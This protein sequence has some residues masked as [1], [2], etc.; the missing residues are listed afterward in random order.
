METRQSPSCGQPRLVEPT[1]SA[2][3]ACQHV[4]VLLLRVD[5]RVL[6]QAARHLLEI[7]RGTGG[8]DVVLLRVRGGRSRGRGESGSR[9]VVR[10][11]GSLVD[12]RGACVLDDAREF[13]NHV[14]G[15]RRGASSA[16]HEVVRVNRHLEVVLRGRSERHVVR[17]SR[18][19]ARHVHP[20]NRGAGHLGGQE[21]EGAG[22]RG[23]VL[24]LDLVRRGSRDGRHDDEHG[25]S[26]DRDHRHQG[27]GPI[28]G[29]HHVCSSFAPSVCARVATT[30]VRNEWPQPTR[31]R[32]LGY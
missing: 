16:E 26:E 2:A 30:K 24:E 6:G 7:V 20:R 10:F 17:G 13:R 29:R 32:L 21:V 25:G 18:V 9:R 14:R 1:W 22:S 23:F 15:Q 5:Q 28:P 19:G 12:G 11:S 4:R 8:I 31:C 3:G 27:C